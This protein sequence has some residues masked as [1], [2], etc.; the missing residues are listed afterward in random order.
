MDS[1]TL[2]MCAAAFV[3]GRWYKHNPDTA[4]SATI[5]IFVV[6]AAATAIGLLKIFLEERKSGK[7][8]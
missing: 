6:G 1:F 7:F 8:L 5:I 2:L 4:L 3:Y